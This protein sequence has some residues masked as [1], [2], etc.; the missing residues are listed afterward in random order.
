MN[1]IML[2]IETLGDVSGSIITSIGAVQFDI[3][4]GET[5][6][7]FHKYIDIQSSYEAGLK[8]NPSTVLWWLG[9]TDEARQ[10]LINGNKQGL[11]IVNALHEFGQWLSWCPKPITRD[12][13]KPRDLYTWG[14]GPRFDMGIL[15]DAYRKLNL[16]IPWDTRREMCVRTMEFLHPDIKKGTPTVDTGHG[17]NGMGLHDAILD[18]KYQIRYVCGIYKETQAN[19]QLQSFLNQPQ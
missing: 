4:T 11:P 12:F 1:H 16:P 2:D 10:G 15:A 8:M 19:K 6:K 13:Y 7:E 14:R 3:N 9:Q 5:G 18:C 17:S